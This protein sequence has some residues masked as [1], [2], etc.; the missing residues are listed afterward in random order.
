MAMG[1]SGSNGGISA[2]NS[3]NNSLYNLNELINSTNIPTEISFFVNNTCNLKCRHCY[4]G[5][6]KTTQSLSLQEWTSVFDDLISLGARTFGNVGKEPLLNW[7]KT[8]SILKYMKLKKKK[9]TDLRFGFVTNGILLD[10]MKI[11]ELD[12]IMPDYI[13]I[14]IDG[15]QKTHGFIRGEGTYQALMTNLHKLSRYASLSER[16]FFSFTLNRMNA[17]SV[18]EVIRSIYEIGFTNLL[19]SPYVTIDTNDMLYISDDK[20]IDTINRLLEGD[21]IDFSEYENL[22]IY[23]KNDFTTTKPLMERMA[24]IGIIKKD[25]LMVDDYGV[26]FN[27][28]NFGNNTIYFNYMPVDNSLKT[29]IR[30]SHDGYVGNCLDMF[31]DDYPVRAVGNVRDKNIQEMLKS[32]NIEAVAA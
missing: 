28:Y 6:S 1:F 17:S 13:D 16:I 25:E 11:A 18:A 8:K 2:T 30:I 21:L 24:D 20:I 9:H 3:F 26:I 22:N 12:E 5:Y 15:N 29:A 14:S 27:K 10:D 4:V 32:V 19:I 31:Y 23:I 7:D